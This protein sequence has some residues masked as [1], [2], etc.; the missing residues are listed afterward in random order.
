MEFQH[1]LDLFD[2]PEN[3][4]ALENYRYPFPKILIAQHPLPQRDQSRMMVVDRGRR[5]WEHLTIRDLPEFLRPGD[6][7]VFN[8]T[9]VMPAKLLGK[10]G[11]GKNVEILL[12]G[13]VDYGPWTVDQKIWKGLGKP[14][15]KIREGM[16]I[17]F[18]A[19]LRGKVVQKNGDGLQIRFNDDRLIEKAGLPPLPPY[20][21]R[22]P[23]IADRERYQSIF[24][25]NTGSAAA[26]TASFHFTEELVKKLKTKGVET[27]FVT[28]HVSR[29]TFLPIRTEDV[30]QHKMHGER[31]CVPKETQTKIKQAKGDGRRVI[32]VGTTVVRAL[33]SDW[34][35]S[36]T[37][38]FITP[39]FQFK[40]V[41]ALLTNF[42]QPASTL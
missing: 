7:L 17:E 14:F 20:I 36:E 15:R 16:E 26:P 35:Q 21:R 12:L 39:G 42:H 6:L 4:R 29:D 41:D 28:L 25:K 9:R 40:I 37:K 8:D 27:A 18:N 1:N 32:A 13:T 23:E 22:A 34:S 38:L 31:F 5:G 11:Q 2:K 10:D 3:D 30:T 19:G 24:A 33:E